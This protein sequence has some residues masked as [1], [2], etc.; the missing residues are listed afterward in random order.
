[1]IV[2]V[3]EFTKTS[4]TMVAI[5]ENARDC[6]GSFLDRKSDYI[7][8]NIDFQTPSFF[9]EINIPEATYPVYFSSYFEELIRLAASWNPKSTS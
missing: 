2:S 4:G 1:M 5:I 9:S 8:C 3:T 7:E 6:A